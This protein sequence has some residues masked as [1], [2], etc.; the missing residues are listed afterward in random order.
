MSKRFLSA[1]SLSDPSSDGLHIKP[2]MWHDD[3]KDEYNK[4]EQDVVWEERLI[5]PALEPLS[6]ELSSTTSSSPA[7]GSH[8]NELLAL[9]F[10]TDNQTRH[11]RVAPARRD[12]ETKSRNEGRK[13]FPY[14]IRAQLLNWLDRHHD[15][16]YATPEEIMLLSHE[17]GLSTLQIRTF[18][19]NN[20]ARHLGR[21]TN[22]PKKRITSRKPLSCPE[23]RQQLE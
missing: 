2:P 4:M 10:P 7:I 23:D 14:S 5:L 3:L 6:P 21:S 1:F 8:F 15:H 12:N 11:K 16:P 19:V 20:R 22:A 9:V 17:T 13:N 18:L